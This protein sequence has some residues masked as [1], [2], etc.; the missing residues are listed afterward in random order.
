MQ[1]E[2]VQR[3]TASPERFWAMW[4]EDD[5]FF[6]ARYAAM[7]CQV[8]ER[9]VERHAGRSGDVVTRK[10]AFRPDRNLPSFLE[11]LL[12]GVRL[13]RERSVYDPHSRTCEVSV[14]LPV[15]GSRTKF[16]GVY[17]TANAADGGFDR[18]WR[19]RC[20]I[21]I[22]LIGGRLEKFILGELETTLGAD[23]RFIQRWL[24]EHP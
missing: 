12:S 21:G 16:A 2:V 10:V 8:V 20:E 9:T 3:F 23:Q 13:V 24:D 1:H 7:K 11:A 17:E 19:G 22:P 6:N 5:G 18:V 14:E 4:M 15:I